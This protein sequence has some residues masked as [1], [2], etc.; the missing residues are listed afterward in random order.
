MTKQEFFK[1]FL[2]N[3]DETGRFIVKS[4]LTG[5]TYCVEAIDPKRDEIPKAVIPKERFGDINPATG[6]T[7]GAYGLKYKGSIKH[8]ESMITEENG[9]L[10][11][12][13]LPVG[14]SPYAYI[15]QIDEIRYAEGFRPKTVVT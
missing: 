4:Y 10:N 7:E 2:Q 8:E 1:R 6:K 5:I 13:Q 9:L 12:K 14:V 15:N 3:T 11:I